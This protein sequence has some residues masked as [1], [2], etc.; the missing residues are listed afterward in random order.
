MKTKPT[1]SL[2]KPAASLLLLPLALLLPLSTLRA[3]TQDAP[4]SSIAPKARPLSN[5]SHLDKKSPFEFE[6]AKEEQIAAADPF[7]GVS[8]AGYCGSG[9][10][11]TVYLIAGKEKKRI[12]VFGDGSPYKKRDTS[13]YRVIGIKRGKS[14]KTTFVTL[15]KDGV[16]KD[17]GFEE[18]TLRPKGGAGPVPG[19]QQPGQGPPGQE[20]RPRPIIPRPGGVNP[21]MQQPYQAPQAFIPGQGN[22]NL[23][24]PQQGQVNLNNPAAQAQANLANQ[25]LMNQLT[26]ANPQMQTPQPVIPGQ[27]Q[28]QTGVMTGGGGQPQR[29]GPPSR[30]RVVLP[31][32]QQ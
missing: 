29:P 24:L 14:L 7:E 1:A 32:T 6:P 16:Q 28:P 9:N 3:D 19:G 2:L 17:V 26:G 21:A 30:R 12:S 4:E 15:E 22:N 20:G 5:Y 13:G 8:L 31:T 11:M 10:T 25:Q 27:P 23:T 18:D